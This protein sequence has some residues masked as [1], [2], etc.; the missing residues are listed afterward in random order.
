M[1]GLLLLLYYY[2]ACVSQR[3]LIILFTLTAVFGFPSTW[4][5]GGKEQGSGSGGKHVRVG[6]D[7][8][9]CLCAS[10][11]HSW[12]TAVSAALSVYPPPLPLHYPSITP[13]LLLHY[14]SITPQLLL[15]YPSITPPLLL[16]YPFIT[17]S[18]TP[19]LPLHYP[20]ITP[21]LPLHDVMTRL[22]SPVTPEKNE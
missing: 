6:S 5:E 13:P 11:H 8:G 3:W 9:T 21:P 1:C 18:I 4:N 19:P 16:H 10:H 12:L 17:P 7:F 2:L 20:F 22:S 14:P 15:H